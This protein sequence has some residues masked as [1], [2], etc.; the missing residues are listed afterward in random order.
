M[1]NFGTFAPATVSCPHVFASTTS[2]SWSGNISGFSS[3]VLITENTAVF[4]P[5][6]TAITTIAMMVNP[7]V[8]A[9]E[10]PAN[11]RSRQRFSTQGRER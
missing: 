9:S 8:F 10:R 5:I 11:F 4:T 1:L 3:T 7:G 2:E 6:P